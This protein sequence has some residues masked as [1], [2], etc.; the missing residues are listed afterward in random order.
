MT[1]DPSAP[2]VRVA[3]LTKS[4]GGTPVLAGVDL[5]VRAGSVH[6]LLGPNGAG[7]TTTVRIACGLLEPDA[8]TV[9]VGGRDML[10]HPREAQRVL[11]LSQARKAGAKV[12]AR[13]RGRKRRASK[14]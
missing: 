13:G 12:P 1:E 8:G 14:S 3:G 5:E 6:A 4:F 10:A 11:G 9:E 7:K 2:L